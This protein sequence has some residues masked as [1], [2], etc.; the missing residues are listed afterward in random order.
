[1]RLPLLPAA[2]KLKGPG[3]A[4]SGEV[5]EI[6]GALPANLRASTV[7]F[8]VER[9]PGEIPPDSDH[10]KA[11]DPVLH[12]QSVPVEGSRAVRITLPVSAGYKG[13]TLIVRAAVEGEE[14]AAG[15]VLRVEIQTP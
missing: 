9:P 4:K 7:T 10:A 3:A 2:V 5:M 1:V 12:R 11:D 14:G 13:E 8:T 15:G 6:E